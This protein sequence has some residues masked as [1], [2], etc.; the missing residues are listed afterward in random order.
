M[1]ETLPEMFE[2]I[3]K[4]P[5]KKEKLALL[6]KY[7]STAFKTIICIA[8]EPNFVWDL[9]EGIPPYKPLDKSVAEDA[10]HESLIHA[11]RRMYIFHKGNTKLPR[12]KLEAQFI[13]LL[14]S[15]HWSEA[16]F[17]CDLRTGDWKKK[18]EG[19]SEALVRE[20]YP[21]LLTESKSPT[22]KKKSNSDPK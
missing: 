6:K 18:Y 21:G 11:A 10:A 19:V 8:L 17:L 15:L 22:G 20:A 9:P 7:D 16:Q 13:G 2:K 4:A 12:I 14:E 3:S 5:S 1:R